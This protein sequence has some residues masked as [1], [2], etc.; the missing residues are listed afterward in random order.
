MNW[1]RNPGWRIAAKDRFVDRDPLARVEWLSLIKEPLAALCEGHIR[2]REALDMFEWIF[3]FGYYGL[4]G[5]D[6]DGP[7]RIALGLMLHARADERSGS[8]GVFVVR[9]AVGRFPA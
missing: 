2:Q 4:P 7:C 9:S 1:A 6:V 5:H 8:A 3:G